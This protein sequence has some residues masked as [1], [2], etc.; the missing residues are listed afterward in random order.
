MEQLGV[1]PDP[2]IEIAALDLH[3][4]YGASTYEYYVKIQDVFLENNDFEAAEIWQKISVVLL[5]LDNSSNALR[6]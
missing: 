2:F 5:N 3:K 4:Q 1:N 6:H